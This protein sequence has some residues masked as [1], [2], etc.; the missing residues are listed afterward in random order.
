MEVENR[1]VSDLR[2]RLALLDAGQLEGR[3]LAM[4]ADELYWELM[5]G[6][7]KDLDTPEADVLR[8]TLHDIASQWEIAVA[9]AHWY[10]HGEPSPPPA[11]EADLVAAWTRRAEE[12]LG[13]VYRRS[14][15]A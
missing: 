14:Q 10:P 4:W 15:N 2:Q 6:R 5:E 1:I 11:F 12:L 7:Y 8:D 13:S 3:D 9:S